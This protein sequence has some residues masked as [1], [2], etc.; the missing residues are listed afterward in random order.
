VA[1]GGVLTHSWS[2]DGT[3]ILYYADED[4]DE[5]RELYSVNP[6]GT[7]H[8]KLNVPLGVGQ[9]LTGFGWINGGSRFLYSSDEETLGFEEAYTVLQDGTGRVK[10][11]GAMIG[12][13]DVQMVMPIQGQDK[14]FFTA[15]DATDGVNELFVVDSDGMNRNRITTG[16]M[17]PGATG[18]D[19]VETHGATFRIVYTADEDANGDLELYT[20][21]LT[22]AGRTKLNAAMAMNADVESFK[23]SPTGSHVA[24]IAD[25][26]VDGQMEVFCVRVGGSQH[27]HLTASVPVTSTSSPQ[28]EWSAD[29]TFLSIHGR[30]ETGN[31]LGTYVVEPDGTSFVRILDGAPAGTITSSVA[32]SLTAD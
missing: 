9:A 22:G 13:G 20:T 32:W 4:I 23:I 19:E 7:G 16:T 27:T 25:A 1:G 29:G 21:S 18:V 6:D 3:R 12:T 17:G 10:L 14:V 15:D 24:Y 26:L 28:V 31:D 30:Y 8:I 2:P 5:L 11:N